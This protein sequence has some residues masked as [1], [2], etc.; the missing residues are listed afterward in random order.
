MEAIDYAGI[1]TLIRVHEQELLGPDLFENLLKAKDLTQALA[2]LQTTPYGAVSETFES[3]LLASL[4]ETYQLIEEHL[5]SDSVIP[6]LFSLLYTY[7]N[8]KVLLKT[9]LGGLDLGHLVVP[10]GAFSVEALSQLVKTG[11]S[12]TLPD[13]LV[14]AVQYICQEYQEF[15]RLEAIDILMDR[16]YFTHVRSVAREIGDQVISDLVQAWADLYNVTC[17]YRLRSRQLSHAFLKSILSEEGKLETGELIALAMSGNPD[18]L[19]ARLL[20]TDYG[21]VIAELTHL[22]GLL[23]LEL[24]ADRLTHAHLKE[25]KLEVFGFL[26]I[27]AFIYYKEMEVKNLRLILTGKRNGFDETVLRERM[28][29]IYDA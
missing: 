13:I 3:T 5:P 26:P 24:A 23:P 17:I 25:A 4:T 7:H 16:S 19:Q 27:L 6:Q 2:L 1:N 28:R 11:Y 21:Q 12:E 18:L 8:L 20:E 15:E 9:Q 14:E 10:I 29:P 22:D